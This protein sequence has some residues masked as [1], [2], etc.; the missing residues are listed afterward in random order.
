[1]LRL[2]RILSLDICFGTWGGAVLASRL[3]HISMPFSWFFLL[4]PATWVVYTLEHLLDAHRI[5]ETAHTDRHRFHY[6]QRYLLWT[7]IVGVL[8]IILFFCL[9]QK[10]WLFFGF[11]MFMGC[12]SGGYFGLMRLPRFAK[13]KEAG[14]ALIYTLGI[15]GLPLWISSRSSQSWVGMGLFFLIAYLNL[16][17]YSSYDFEVD[18]QDHSPSLATQIGLARLSQW[19][20]GIVGVFL[21]IWILWVCRDG[22]SRVEQLLLMSM[23]LGTL[24]LFPLKEKL[25]NSFLYR[26]WGESVF[27]WPLIL[28]YLKG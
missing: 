8:G 22:C 2:I 5:G 28:I 6:H 10:L 14:V 20:Y 16:L 1:M 12:L 26:S 7:M 4:P 21:F 25:T 11:G 9:L 15:W 23:A 27:Y 18:L 24:L 19:I 3:T 13:I 17:C